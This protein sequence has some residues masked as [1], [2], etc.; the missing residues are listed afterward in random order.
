MIISLKKIALVVFTLSILSFC[1]SNPVISFS[2]GS[3]N[4][5]SNDPIN[6]QVKI[7]NITGLFAAHIVVEYDNSIL[8]LSNFSSGD[9]L[10][11]NSGGYNVQ[12]MS[13]PPV[14]SIADSIT[15]D[16][17]ILGR[18]SVD[19]SGTIFNLT[20]I[21]IRAGSTVVKIR[22][23]SLRDINNSEIFAETDSALITITSRVV[24]SKIFLEGV[25]SGGTMDNHLNTHGLLPHIHP[26]S[27]APWNYNGREAVN[28]NFFESDTNIVDWI[29]LE[30]RTGTASNTI[31]E[32]RAVFVKTD[33][34]VVDLDG[35]S[36]VSFFS[37]AGP[38][39][40][41]V[42]HR[43]HLAIMSSVPLNISASSTLYDFTDSNS[44][45][46]GSNAMKDLGGGVLGLVTGEAALDGYITGSDFNIYNP[47]FRIGARGYLITDWDLDG[48]VNG[49]D[50]N[51]FNPN[52]RA[53]RRTN[54][55]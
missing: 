44:K 35:V 10:E 55:P 14:D 8:T 5:S 19:G 42:R 39:Y 1:Q 28:E 27:S 29:L 18:S 48:K 31:V 30:L 13:Y 9:F 50:F 4:V 41:V 15:V 23:F 54:V 43:N 26:Y 16:Q 20:F 36:P 32:R 53:G 37:T 3:Y 33:G 51:F 38:Y 40:L 46:F 47:A 22:S 21:P 52:F 34:S 12:L 25:F 17:A 7:N 11:S 24:N 2:P 45:A 49:T 6:F